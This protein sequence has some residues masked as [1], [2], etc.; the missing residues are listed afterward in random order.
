[1]KDKV[2][3]IT[4]ASRGIGEAVA[5]NLAEQGYHTILVSRSKEALEKIQQEIKEKGGQASVYIVNV[6]Q[7]KEVKQCVDDV[8]L[9]F[10]RVDMLFNNAGILHMG[11]TDISLEKIDETI[12]VNLQGMI[13]FGKFVAE[14]MKKQKF[15]HIIYLA[16]LGGKRA[17]PFGGVYCASKYGVVGYSEAQFKE[18]MSYGIKVTVICPS[19]VATDMTKQA[20]F[21]SEEMIQPDDIVKAV[22]FLLDLGPNAAI[23]ELQVE[24]TKHVVDL[25]L[26]N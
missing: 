3:I 9:R 20:D 12:Q 23:K 16:S 22:S 18:L 17:L 6:A 11:T 21:P 5:K 15:G 2:A 14:Q 10:G 19:F 8:V 25:T 4:G 7:A 26:R 13:Y 24:C 1:M